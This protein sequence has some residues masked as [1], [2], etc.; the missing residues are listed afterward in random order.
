MLKCD[1]TKIN[2]TTGGIV[3]T[4]KGVVNEK[5][6]YPNLRRTFDVEFPGADARYDYLCWSVTVS[7][8]GVE[9]PSV[10]KILKVGGPPSGVI[11]LD[12]AY[13]Y[14]S[15]TFEI[16]YSIPD[17]NG[18]SLN[19]IDVYLRTK[20]GAYR[21]VC[22][23]K[24][25]IQASDDKCVVDSFLLMDNPFNLTDDDLISVYVISENA[26]GKSKIT[27]S[28]KKLYASTPP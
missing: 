24:K 17:K 21:R 2:L 14:G 9:T 11:N 26:F 28:T 1:R 19:Y 25:P 20:D 5:L 13:Q 6:L 22:H 12:F 23:K 27:Y 3:S 18:S 15:R 8:T 16:D 10:K 7:K 4:T